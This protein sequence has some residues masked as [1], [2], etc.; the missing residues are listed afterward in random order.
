[1]GNVK[2]RTDNGRLP[3]TLSNPADQALVVKFLESIDVKTVPFVP[4][5]IRKSGNLI[6]VAFDSI[7]GGS[8]LIQTKPSFDV[9]WSPS[10][11]P[12]TG[13]GQ[14]LEVALPIDANTKF[15]RL[16]AAP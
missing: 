8:Y 5:A 16:V 2:H 15:V 4:L 12:L 1:V 10:G 9:S 14:R 6:Y 11:A 7:I 13:N 3:D